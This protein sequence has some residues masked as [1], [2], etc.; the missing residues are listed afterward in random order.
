MTAAKE[1]TFKAI[2]EWFIN[3][4]YNN[5]Q[6]CVRKLTH[7]QCHKVIFKRA[8]CS[9]LCP[10]PPL[11]PR[12]KDDGCDGVL[13]Q[14][15]LHSRSLPLR[16]PLFS[17]VQY[18]FVKDARMTYFDVPLFRLPSVFASFPFQLYCAIH[19]MCTTRSCAIHFCCPFEPL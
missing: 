5:R 17:T 18:F 14:R 13:F 15:A 19:F 10:R 8:P 4:P 3:Y 7:K 12:C 16:M 6:T 2:V 11:S 9:C 1:G